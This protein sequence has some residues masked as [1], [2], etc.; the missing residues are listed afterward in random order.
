MSAQ[1]G[2]T[3]TGTER[4]LGREFGGVQLLRGTDS[5]GAATSGRHSRIVVL[6]SRMNDVVGTYGSRTS[7]RE[8]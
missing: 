2:P 6:G 3:C 8:R 1:L 5:S 7:A 4:L